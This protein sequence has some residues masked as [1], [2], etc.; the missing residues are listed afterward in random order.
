MYGF[1]GLQQLCFLVMFLLDVAGPRLMNI[2]EHISFLRNA[3]HW[4]L[5]PFVLIGYSLVELYALHE[6]M[7]RGKEVCKHG[8]SKKGALQ[9][10]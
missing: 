6:V 2:K 5:T 3:L 7:V 4:L 8:A 10:A 1:A 9:A